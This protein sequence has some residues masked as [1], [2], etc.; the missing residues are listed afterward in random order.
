MSSNREIALL[1]LA[2]C[3]TSPFL[4][5]ICSGEPH[6]DVQLDVSTMR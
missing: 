5:F 4:Q 6:R 2:I 3:H 1:N